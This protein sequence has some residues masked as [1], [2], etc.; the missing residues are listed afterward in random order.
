MEFCLKQGV[1]LTHN[2]TGT[3]SE[4]A[5]YKRSN[6][7]SG[8]IKIYSL[9]TCRGPRSPSSPAPPPSP[10]P[11]PAGRGAPAQQWL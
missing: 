9:G 11:P 10:P 6:P 7:I 3:V 8:S 1:L 2:K 4:Q 5:R